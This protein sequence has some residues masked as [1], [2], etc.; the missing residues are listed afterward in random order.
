MLV[1]EMWRA[2]A[3]GDVVSWDVVMVSTVLRAIVSGDVVLGA[4]V[5]GGYMGI[6]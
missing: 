3:L 5:R 4:T 2:I 1:S 6:I